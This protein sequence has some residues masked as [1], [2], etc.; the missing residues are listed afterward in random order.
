LI[1]KDYEKNVIYAMIE[2]INLLTRNGHGI[3]A[4]CLLSKTV[5]IRYLKKKRFC[6]NQTNKMKVKQISK[7]SNLFKK[8]N[9]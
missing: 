8:I 1:L 7:K 3:L 6:E 9:I 2:K 5:D 4:L